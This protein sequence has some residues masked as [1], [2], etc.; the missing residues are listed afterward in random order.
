MLSTINLTSAAG[1]NA[2]SKCINSAITNITYA[3]GGSATGA[4]VTGLPSGVTF[5]FNNGT[6]VLTISGTPSV[7]GTFNYIVTANGPCPVSSTGTIKVNP[8][9]NQNSIVFEQLPT[10]LGQGV[11]FSLVGTPTGGDGTYTYQW[12]RKNNCGNGGGAS[13][14]GSWGDRKNLFTIR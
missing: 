5:N 14:S 4:T 9:I 6:K 10:C 7:A 11:M 1:T 13:D 2:Q 12:M 3:I 8:Q